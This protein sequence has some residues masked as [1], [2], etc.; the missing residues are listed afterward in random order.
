MNNPHLRFTGRPAYELPNLLN[1]FNA[2]TSRGDDMTEDLR[3]QADAIETHAINALDAI[4]DGI[5]A[6]GAAMFSAGTNED[7]P[8]DGRTVA[9]LGSLIKHLA[10]EQQY[11]RSVEGDM[12]TR[13]EMHDQK[14][15]AAMAKKG[16]AK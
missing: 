7:W 9:A 6:I 1:A 3:D 4:G 8:M 14:V 16:G 13:I 11:L 12:H 10:V 5:E 15:E 2:K